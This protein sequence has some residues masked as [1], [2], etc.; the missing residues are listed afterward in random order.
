VG[1]RKM[2]VFS[3][4]NRPMVHLRD[5]EGINARASEAYAIRGLCCANREGSACDHMTIMYSLQC[6]GSPANER[7]QEGKMQRRKGELLD[8]VITL[9]HASAW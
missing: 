1:R 6:V 4:V 5:P 2:R 7:R 9:G 3:D 8:Y